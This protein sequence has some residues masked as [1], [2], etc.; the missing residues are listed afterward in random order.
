MPISDG[1]LDAVGLG[2]ACQLAYQ[3]QSERNGTAKAV[4]GGDVSVYDDFL[5][6]D[7]GTGQLI[8]KT[9]VCGGVFTLQQ[10]EAGKDAGLSLIHI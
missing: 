3:L 2:G 1:L 5:V 8:L 7:D 10:A 6:V 4:A 9:G